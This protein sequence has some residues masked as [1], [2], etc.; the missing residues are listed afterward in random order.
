MVVKGA[1]VTYE[2][3]GLLGDYEDGEPTVLAKQ[4]LPTSGAVQPLTY[5]TLKIEAVPPPIALKLD[6]DIAFDPLGS[7]GTLTLGVSLE[8]TLGDGSVLQTE[9]FYYPITVCRGCLTSYEAKPTRC[10]DWLIAPDFF[11]CF[12][13]QDE[14]YSCL[15]GCW[16]IWRDRVDRYA[17]KMAMLEGFITNLGVDLTTLALPE[18][19]TALI[20]P[21]PGDELTEAAIAALKE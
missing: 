6:R 3:D 9:P 8:V 16:L 13:G 5:L 2:M 7:A 14:R 20:Q 18:D 12:P 1:W 10:C 11:P 21:V 19:F 4:W 17:E 15:T